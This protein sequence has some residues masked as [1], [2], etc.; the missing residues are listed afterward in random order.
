MSALPQR[1][2]GEVFEAEAFGAGFGDP[3]PVSPS[4]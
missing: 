2:V 1:R 3:V 4:R